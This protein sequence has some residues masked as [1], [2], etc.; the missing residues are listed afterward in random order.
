MNSKVDKYIHEQ[1]NE[2][3]Y[4][5]CDVVTD[6][7]YNKKHIW[8]CDPKEY[9]LNSV[10][11]QVDHI[12]N[13]VE[14]FQD[15]ELITNGERLLCQFCAHQMQREANRMLRE[16]IKA[17]GYQF[18]VTGRY[19]DYGVHER[20]TTVTAKDREEAI[21]KFVAQCGNRYNHFEVAQYGKEN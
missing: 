17:S 3:Y 20:A 15:A 1:L 12:V 7:E 11:E 16:H 5:C 4:E 9:T 13:A 21:A 14:I 19:I 10:E 18:R 8:S 6:Y 2:L